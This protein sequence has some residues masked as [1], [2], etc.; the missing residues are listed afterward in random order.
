MND[1]RITAAGR[2][3]YKA[4]TQHGW[5][6]FN[7]PFDKLDPIAHS[8]FRGIVGQALLAVDAVGPDFSKLKYE[9]PLPNPDAFQRAKTD[10]DIEAPFKDPRHMGITGGSG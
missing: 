2:V 4:G 1:E 9:Q 6:G 10:E 5:L 7:V 3:I 8:E